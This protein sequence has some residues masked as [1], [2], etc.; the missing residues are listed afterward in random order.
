[1]QKNL[2]FAALHVTINRGESMDK[3]D[4]NK[5]RKNHFTEIIE[6]IFSKIDEGIHVVDR[7]GIT[8]I[9][10]QAMANM[11]EMNRSDVLGKP[12][13]E[14]FSHIPEDQSTMLSALKYGKSS[15]DRQQTYLNF[16]GK[17]VTTINNT[18]PIVINGQIVGAVEIAKNITDIQNLSKAIL[19]YQKEAAEPDQDKAKAIKAYTFDMIAG[20]NRQFLEAIEKAKRA[21]ES[22]VS[23]LVAGDTGTGKEM[24]AQSIHYHSE[25]SGKPLLAQ[26]CAAIPENLLEGLLFGT[27]KGGFT[28]ALDRAG[29]FEQANGGSLILDEIS[30]MPYGLQGKLLRV[31]QED[32]IRRVGGE[33]DIPVDVRIIATINEPAENLIN[34]G[35]LRKDLYYR[36]AV[37]NINLPTLKERRDDII[38]LANLFIEKHSKRLGKE[39]I[40]ISDEAAQVLMNHDYPGNVR[41][42]ENI[43]LSALTMAGD[44]RILQDHHLSIRKNKNVTSPEYDKIREVGLTEYLNRLEAEFLDKAMDQN[45]GNIS[46]AAESLGISRQSLQHKLKRYKRK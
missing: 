42:L 40:A 1:M 26:N 32:Y 25:R 16:S 45:R 31:L 7:D 29:L 37:I 3:K 30:A 2:H 15:P 44:S 39:V 17:E 8:I 20:R 21:S 43:I 5:D 4:E 46:R 11:E 18:H 36:L 33:K 10:N 14:I 9:Y 23:V 34:R 41:E 35:M 38:L 19:E 24:F 27:S 6:A 13:R 22:N 28:G 12:F